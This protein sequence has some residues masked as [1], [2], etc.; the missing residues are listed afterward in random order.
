MQVE[1]FR[2]QCQEDQVFFAWHFG[3]P[4]IS[5]EQDMMRIDLF[6]LDSF[7][8]EVCIDSQ[9]NRIVMLNILEQTSDLE[10]YLDY[11]PLPVLRKVY[12][13]T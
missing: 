13:S 4:L 11:L 12:Q 10:R 3:T 6:Y 9:I 8:I 7:Y 2:K 5:L 1:F